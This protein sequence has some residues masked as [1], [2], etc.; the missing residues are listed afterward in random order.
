LSGKWKAATLRLSKK[1]IKKGP[2][3][4]FLVLKPKSLGQPGLT[5]G[6]TVGFPPTTAIT[7]LSTTPLLSHV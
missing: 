1:S 4:P 5:N 6:A 3:G 7:F 2:D